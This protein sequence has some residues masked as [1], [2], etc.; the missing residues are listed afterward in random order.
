VSAERALRF[1]VPA[2][3]DDPERVSGGNV[4]DRRVRDGLAAAGWTVTV[5]EV[6]DGD[7]VQAALAEV[8]DDGTALVDGLVA[9]WAPDAIEAAA[10]RSRVLV[11]AH[12]VA[13]AF[14]DADPVAADGERRALGHATRVVATSNWTASELV[15]RGIVAERRVS[16]ARPGAVDGSASHG[17]AGELLC[18]GAVAPHKG[19]DILLDALG[20]LGSFDWSCTV[21]GSPDADPGFAG[22]VASAAAR[23]G[24]RVRLTGVLA[25]SELAAAYRRAGLLVAPS[26]AESF[27]MAI[28][29]ARARGLP[30]I[31]AAVG[32]IPETVA[33][34][35]AVLVK[36]G[37]PGA[38]ASALERWMTDPALRDR[39]RAEAAAARS[40]SPRWADTV[41]RIDRVLRAA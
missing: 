22:R 8:P 27:G 24:S 7:A 13:A 4:Y 18:V 17:E 29:D 23:L 28:A 39:L 11:L 34:G 5:V 41:E 12:M 20:R 10:A 1:V 14:P 15:R 32:G 16:V 26:R 21:A 30:V 19:Q 38:L 35:G 3:V 40:R 2:G 37:D 31:A 36:A 9:S 25:E 33:G 6:A